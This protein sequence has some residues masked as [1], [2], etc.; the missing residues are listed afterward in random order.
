MSILH[1]GHWRQH[2]ALDVGTATTR[3]A[4]GM[5]QQM[6][7]PSFVGTKR[8]L[9]DGVVIDGKIIAHILQPLLARTRRL[10]LFK[11]CVLACA[12]SDA[13]PEERQLLV[14]SIMMGGAASVAVIPEPLAAAIGAGIDIS[15]PY[16]RMIIDIGEGV[17]DCAV[18][19]S[20]KITVACAIRS[21]CHRL[22][23]TIVTAAR[24]YGYADISDS[25]ADMLLRTCGLVRSADHVGSSLVA[26]ALQ[27][28][29][30]EIA[31]TIAAFLQDLP[32]ELG[33]E[34]IENGICLTGG[35][36]LIPG[37]REYFEQR[38]GIGVTIATNPRD[39]VIDGARIILPA[40]LSLNQWE[41]LCKAP[42]VQIYYYA[43]VE[44]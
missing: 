39:A 20:S 17:T 36:A 23:H 30:A 19:R 6:E 18:I 3:L 24:Q 16:A 7:Q 5:S 28:L 4:V 34:I 2:V 42:L 37:V 33:C 12:P 31:A 14:D 32:H 11:P 35:G 44:P 1:S 8:A 13:L 9:R 41:N 27:P 29:L 21:G 26:V 10:G 15:S 40:I 25:H 43:E 38:T 22:R